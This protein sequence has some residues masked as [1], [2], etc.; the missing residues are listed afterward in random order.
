MGFA[1]LTWHFIVLFGLYAL[2]AAS[3]EGISKA[4]ISNIAEKD[5]TATAIG[6]YTSF[7]SI[8][9]MLASSFAGLIW[10]TLGMKPMF[11]ISGIGVMCVALYLAV[12]QRY[13]F[14]N[15]KA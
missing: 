3:T 2:Y 7:A 4:L 11:I 10:F 6:F 1:V 14:R 8:C 9:T 5:K 15:S 13:V 12:V